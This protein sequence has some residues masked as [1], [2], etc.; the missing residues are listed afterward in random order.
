M[1][2][3]SYS[4]L[5]TANSVRLLEICT[6]PGCLSASTRFL[7]QYLAD[8]AIVCKLHTVELGTLVLYDALSYTWGDPLGV[9]R[10]KDDAEKAVKIHESKMPIICN[11]KVLRVGANLHDALLS[12]RKSPRDPRSNLQKLHP[13]LES[14]P[15]VQT[16]IW[17]DAVCINQD[18]VA[19]RN[20]QVTLMRTSPSISHQRNPDSLLCCIL[21]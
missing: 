10:S 15:F 13:D 8:D 1:T 4:P 2:E 11:E 5:P 20:S 3:F 14:R 21:F 7:D 19:E 18:N 16:N 9:Y 6:E 12:P 17:I